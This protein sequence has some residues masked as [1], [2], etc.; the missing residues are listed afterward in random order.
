MRATC[1]NIWPHGLSQHG[2]ILFE[3]SLPQQRCCPRFLP[4]VLPPL[5]LRI[6]F[7]I[8]LLVTPGV[9]QLI[10]L[11]ARLLSPFPHGRSISKEEGLYRNKPGLRLRGVKRRPHSPSQRP[12]LSLQAPQASTS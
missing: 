12:W 10:V 3:C 1:V 6:L 5:P 7:H 11:I 9:G 8:P 2:S 4:P